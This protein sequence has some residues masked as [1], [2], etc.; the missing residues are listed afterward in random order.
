MSA[1]VNRLFYL[2]ADMEMQSDAVVSERSKTSAIA[3]EKDKSGAPSPAKGEADF[4]MPDLETFLRASNLDRDALSGDEVKVSTKLLK[5]LLSIAVS[6]LHFDEE[7]YK[8]E[9]P[10]VGLAHKQGKIPSLHE[11]FVH[12]GWFEGRSPGAYF[13][14]TDYY[15]Q[16]YPDIRRAMRNRQITDL[17][18][19]YTRTGRAEGRV[20][21]KE[22]FAWKLR[23][24][25]AFSRE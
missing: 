12:T 17:T 9:N 20:G 19:H 24:D 22:Q 18:D 14:D 8:K 7:A 1:S 6:R 21:T 15:V 3:S 23:W 2:G 4:F 10:D 13:V 11:H 16:Q 5:L 25:S